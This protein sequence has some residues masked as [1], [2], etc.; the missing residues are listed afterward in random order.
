MCLPDIHFLVK[1]VNF[2]LLYFFQFA[3]EFRETSHF[4]CIWY[5]EFI[6]GPNVSSKNSKNSKKSYSVDLACAIFNKLITLF[7]GLR[8]KYENNN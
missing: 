4:C 5:G 7:H 6:Y 3:I 1:T 8:C 2:K